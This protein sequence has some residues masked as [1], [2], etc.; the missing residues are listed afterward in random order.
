M[1]GGQFF[2]ALTPAQLTGITLGGTAD[3]GISQRTSNSQATKSHRRLIL[4]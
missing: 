4:E 3:A 1:L 2:S